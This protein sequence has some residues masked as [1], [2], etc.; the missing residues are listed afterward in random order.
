MKKQ[1]PY[2]KNWIALAVCGV[3][4]AVGLIGG[5]SAKYV[6]KTALSGTGADITVQQVGHETDFYLVENNVTMEADG[7]YNA[8]KSGD[9]ALT[10]EGVSYLLIPGTMLPKTPIVTVENKTELP[11]YLYLVIDGADADAELFYA[12]DASW[13]K[14]DGAAG[15]AGTYVYTGGG[16]E[17]VRLAGNSELAVHVLSSDRMEV[18]KTALT[19]LT[20]KEREVTI[21]CYLVQITDESKTA[22]EV[23]DERGGLVDTT[24]KLTNKFYVADVGCVISEPGWTDGG[25]KKESILIGAAS[26]R[27]EDGRELNAPALLRARLVVNWINDDGN[28]VAVPGMAAPEISVSSSWQKI[29][30]YYYYR[31]I[32]QPGE[33]RELLAAPI[34]TA[35][36]AYR[37]QVEVLAEA[38]QAT[39]LNGETKAV[40]EAWGHSYS[41]GSWQ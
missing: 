25:T 9:G 5:L 10:E 34:E 35:A 32:V 41:G 36:G 20:E 17:A 12:I 23:F 27:D 18:N 14:L 33:S 24:A 22:Q 30:D 21:L 39:G 15:T 16:S 13:T 4:L 6:Q 19:K 8:I 40:K 29:G 37:L 2:R 11:A 3:L 28:I 31:G 26:R 38:I 1:A 7:S